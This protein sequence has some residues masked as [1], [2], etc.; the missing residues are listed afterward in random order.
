[1]MLCYENPTKQPQ[2]ISKVQR[3][4]GNLFLFLLGCGIGATV[5]LL[6]APKP[7]KE[8]RDDIS[9]A[10]SKGY[11][12]TL[13]AASTLKRRTGEYIDAAKDTG[14]KVLD[15]ASSRMSALKE[16]FGDDIKEIGGMLEVGLERTAE[17]APAKTGW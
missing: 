7:G 13:N 1:M 15:V 16:E 4:S 11:N 9:L 10:A 14:K 3:F 6:F 5:A 17:S 8:L 2:Q 12:E